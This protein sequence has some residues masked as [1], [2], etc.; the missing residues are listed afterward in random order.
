MPTDSKRTSGAGE[1]AAA[2]IDSVNPAI[3][4]Q[5]TRRRAE[6]TRAR[7]GLLRRRHGGEGDDNDGHRHNDGQSEKRSRVHRRPVL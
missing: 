3:A 5:V 6:G 4:V 7:R 1:R 2:K